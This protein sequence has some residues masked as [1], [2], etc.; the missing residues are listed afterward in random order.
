MTNNQVNDLETGLSQ[1][2]VS[3]QVPNP[4]KHSE[5]Q[6]HIGQ[7]VM[8]DIKVYLHA[9]G[10]VLDT[11]AL[12][13][14]AVDD[15]DI[16]HEFG[17]ADEL[18]NFL[19]DEDSAVRQEAIKLIQQGK[20]EEAK[21]LIR[22][23]ELEDADEA[24]VIAPDIVS[25][26]QFFEGINHANDLVRSGTFRGFRKLSPEGKAIVM[27]LFNQSFVG[28]STHNEVGDNRTD[29]SLKNHDCYVITQEDKEALAQKISA[30]NM[31]G[32]YHI[33]EG[34]NPQV[35]ILQIHNRNIPF[36]CAEM[37]GR[38]ANDDQEMPEELDQAA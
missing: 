38:A 10:Q 23:R 17:L 6:A 36:V 28:E 30:L 1:S 14:Y 35:F 21:A 15:A 37:F 11:V 5:T 22:E 3:E 29:D 2:D 13:T 8:G 27:K 34:Q 26:E 32:K 33:I 19:K 12:E 18:R 24:K 7:D 25:V 16:I 4:E 20:T 31:P 9:E